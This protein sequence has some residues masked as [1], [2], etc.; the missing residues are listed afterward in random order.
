[1]GS[2]GGSS[3]AGDRT[4]AGG[5]GHEWYIYVVPQLR[6]G[7]LAPDPEARTGRHARGDLQLLCA[8]RFQPKLGHPLETTSSD[9]TL[10]HP[11]SG[12]D[13]GDTPGIA[14]P[15]ARFW[16][17]HIPTPDTPEARTCLRSRA[18]YRIPALALHL[19]TRIETR[20]T[21]RH[22][23]HVDTPWPIFAIAHLTR[24]GDVTSYRHCPMHAH[25]IS[26]G[27]AGQ[28]CHCAV[29]AQ[30]PPRGPPFFAR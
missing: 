12:C 19:E 27:I 17:G 9:S 13:P 28:P 18:G 30:I 15:C 7:E 25:I 16:A 14:V 11:D 22:T 4:L 1:M 6:Q 5:Q 29:D 23:R 8:T 10:A 2:G 24:T 3:S 20:I 26:P 21:A